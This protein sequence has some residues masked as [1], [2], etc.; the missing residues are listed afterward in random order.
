MTTHD[1]RSSIRL[2]LVG[3]AIAVLLPSCAFIY[4]YFPDREEGIA[5]GAMRSRTTNMAEFV[6]LGVGRGLHLNDFADV[7]AAVN[8]VK[9]DSSLVYVV[10]LDSS[11][12]EF[13]SYNPGRLA[14]DYPAAG[15]Q[16]GVLD[17]GGRLTITVPVV[18]EKRSLG[19]VVLAVSLARMH[20]D[21][22]RE[23]DLALFFSLVVFVL[24]GAAAWA[25]SS[26]IVEPLRELHAAT[27][28]VAQ[29]NYDVAIPRK[30]HDEI[31]ALA[32]AFDVMVG[33]LR[34]SDA[35]VNAM[36]KDLAAARDD[37]QASERAKAEFLATMSHEIRTPMNGVLGMLGLLLDT[38][39]DAK[40][41]DRAAAAHKSAES[42]LRVINDIL[43]FSKIEAGRL[44]LEMVD[45][46]LR[47]DLEDVIDVLAD[48]ASRKGI[49]LTCVV[50]SAVP[51]LVCGDP[52]RL[53]Q[54]LVNL[55]GN[56]IKFTSQG[57]VILRGRLAE[58]DDE[59]L[60]LRFEV[61]DT[62]IGISEEAQKRL[63]TAFSQADA[64]TT[65]RFGGTG[66]GLA[67]CR[68][69]AKLMGGDIGVESRSGVGST[70]WVTARVGR[71]STT[72]SPLKL[73]AGLRVLAIDDHE[74][75]RELLTQLLHNWNMRVT[76]V[77]DGVLALELLVSA[78][79][80]GYPFDVAIVDMHMSGMDG[81]S[82]ARAIKSVPQL[83]SVPL[84]LLTST[85]LLG[86]G[87]EAA[88]LGFASYLTKPI[89]ASALF[90][91]LTTVLY[92]DR[93]QASATTAAAKKLAHPTGSGARF[94][95]SRI[96]VAEDNQINQ[97]VAIGF[98][99][100]LGHHV[101]VVGNGLEAVDAVRLRPYDLVL[102]DV[103]MPEMDGIEAT[104][105]IRRLGRTG[106][107]H[108]PIIA[109]TANA[110]DGDR[111]RFLASGMDDYVS[112]PIS[113]DKLDAALGRW[114]VGREPDGLDGDDRTRAMHRQHHDR[115]TAGR[116]AAKR[117]P[118]LYNPNQLAQIFGDNSAAI[119]NCTDLFLSSTQPLLEQCAT[120][121]SEQQGEIV[122]RL[123][124]TIR[125]ACG[126][127]G[128]DKMAALCGEMEAAVAVGDWA[129]SEAL[130]KAVAESFVKTVAAIQSSGLMSRSTAPTG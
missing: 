130:S 66:L 20:R 12:Q 121:V 5:L 95:R 24:G 109:M 89:R 80:S 37:A 23:R 1:W 54:I 18:Y 42:L 101:D 65:R 4:F 91:C 7:V 61:I 39:L 105:A 73:P 16:S 48:Q 57:E 96:L 76:T 2:K 28:A 45:F 86:Q 99:N 68:R 102:M 117:D 46:E 83:A 70:F 87:P 19:K 114:L 75:T 103:Q 14:V 26:R 25:M 38:D 118:V 34:N 107:R 93:E 58:A 122:A 55:V 51:A 52:G 22:D 79:A 8:W 6:A 60:T 120:A 59:A 128:A 115:A 106:Q 129:Q 44:E 85:P 41:R 30:T 27:D 47:T 71:S 63:F 67:I 84:V 119:H 112:K 113:R 10:V 43:D 64:S 69:L 111:E 49:A 74:T 32:D 36:V 104:A 97:Q 11:G 88:E 29:G 98:L 123:G 9:Q 92:P 116:A 124:H 125:G 50:D 40:Q 13:A 78:T 127:I 77:E 110:L 72:P 82:L 53:R 62:G 108:L 33:H 94:K 15:R 35:Q 81:A 100:L 31:G 56:A 21:I 126:N 90:D 3:G 17:L